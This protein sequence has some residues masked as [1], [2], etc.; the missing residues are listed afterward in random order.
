MRAV[1]RRMQ[2]RDALRKVVDLI[3]PI[4]EDWRCKHEVPF[5]VAGGC[6]SCR[7]ELPLRAADSIDGEPVGELVDTDEPG[8]K[9]DEAGIRW[10]SAAWL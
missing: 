1:T 7:G 5:G 10:Y 6:N 3:G 8:V 2:V 4:P 9:I